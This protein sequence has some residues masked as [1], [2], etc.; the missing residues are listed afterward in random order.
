MSEISSV[1]GLSSSNVVDFA[2]IRLDRIASDR[3]TRVWDPVF[4]LEIHRIDRAAPAG[5]V[6]RR[7]TEIAKPGRVEGKIRITEGLALVDIL[8]LGGDVFAARFEYGDGNTHF[9]ERAGNGDA[10]RA[11]ADHR[12]ARQKA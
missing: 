3:P 7:A 1:I 2:E 11:A 6:V 9:G 12:D 10:G 4:R 5:P 8:G